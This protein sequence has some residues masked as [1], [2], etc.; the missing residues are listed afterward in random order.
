MFSPIQFWIDLAK[1]L[2]D[3]KLVLF[4][5]VDFVTSWSMTR[6]WLQLLAGLPLLIIALTVVGS[7]V[8]LQV[9]G[10]STLSMNYWEEI[11]RE[12]QTQ[13]L[14][15]ATRSSESVEAG[16]TTS[17][18]GPESKN[19][20]SLVEESLL[21]E[22]S[23]SLL[24]KVLELESSDMR[25]SFLVATS[26]ANQGHLSQAR[27]IMRRI[28]PEGQ[29]GFAAAHAWLA[30]DRLQSLG[31]R[32]PRHL[33][34]VL[35]DLEQARRWSAVNPMLMSSYA[36]LLLREKRT[37]EAIEVLREAG[38]KDS[39]LKIKLASLA[40]QLGNDVLFN[41]IC[42][43]MVEPRKIRISDGTASEVDYI[44]LASLE[45][46]QQHLQQAVDLANAGA[47]AFPMSTGLRRF[48]STAYMKQFEVASQEGGSSDDR[49]TLL[50]L[51]M[52]SDP[53]NPA[54]LEKV[55]ELTAQD[56]LQNEN[57]ANYLREQLAKG[58][59]TATTHLF[60]AIGH[61]KK[62]ELEKA[63]VHLEVASGL[64]PN[65]PIIL[66]NLAIC[67]ARLRPAELPRAQKM[68]EVAI[69]IKGPDAELFDSYGEI[70]AAQGNNIGAIRS[71]EAALSLDQDRPQTR[72]KLAEIYA[73]VEMKE[74]TESLI[75]AGGS[76]SAAGS[77]SVNPD[78]TVKKEPLQKSP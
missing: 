78:G 31:I 54:V 41:S 17:A 34:T 8:H 15:S 27:Q 20:N 21:S 48:L 71:F 76:T 59:A 46:F 72:A 25:A 66:N 30:G 9:I 5:A 14:V 69:K 36:D 40:K 16:K 55:A 24:L 51:A 73:K 47:K 37:D 62:N 61:L 23:T 70:L 77:S 22:Y 33:T 50:D 60:L 74:M 3:P 7:Y 42:A 56:K 6:R 35:Q 29:R 2:M 10:R 57:I 49:I 43:D 26:M 63:M 67:I 39:R 12:N 11:E 65:N 32:E 53:T 64:A 28:A 13:S 75:K 1:L 52:K 44:E 58:K 45:L 38:N 4:G 18:F 68:M 19:S